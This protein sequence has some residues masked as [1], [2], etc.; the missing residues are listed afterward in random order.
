MSAAVE[1]WVTGG[2]Q[3]RAPRHRAELTFD[4]Q[5]TVADRLANVDGFVPKYLLGR[6]PAVLATIMAGAELGLGPLAA[7]RS[8]WIIE[9]RVSLSAE[10]AR[11]LVQ[12]AGHAIAWVELSDAKVSVIGRRRDEEQWTPPIDWSM[13]RAR[14]AKLAGKAVWQQYPRQM[15]EARASSELCHLHFADVLAGIDVLAAVELGEEPEPDKP[16]T[17]VSRVRVR[18]TVPPPALPGEAPSFAPPQPDADAL[19]SPPSEPEEPYGPALLRPTGQPQPAR[20]PDLAPEAP[21]TTAEQPEPPPVPSAPSGDRPPHRPPLPDEPTVESEEGQPAAPPPAP[22]P[23]PVPI[24]QGPMLRRL[25]ARMGETFPGTDR[26][27]MD[28]YRHALVALVTRR[29]D[30]GPVT[31]SGLLTDAEQ[32]GFEAR[33]VDVSMGRAYIGRTPRGTVEW[34]QGGWC[35]EVAFDP[36]TITGR[37]EPSA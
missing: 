4:E 28:A 18:A 3:P 25:H 1:S 13:D 19:D 21:R 36:V 7:L 15:L 33:L 31:S 35:Y 6:P 12:A 24:N 9:G 26:D 22:P 5:L 27:T 34:R 11:G 2:T 37:Q 23:E 8:I 32:M 10:V 17:K 20:A 29:R 16:A 14:R 30:A